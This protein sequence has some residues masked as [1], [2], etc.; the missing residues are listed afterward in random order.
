[1]VDEWGRSFPHQDGL[2][3]TDYLSILL[4]WGGVSTHLLTSA[5]VIGLHLSLAKFAQVD[6]Y[7]CS[8]LCK[9]LPQIIVFS[10]THKYLQF[11]LSFSLSQLC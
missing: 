8:H 1:M 9:I 7:L 11:A 10:F 2:R 3:L 5:F 6:F 4:G